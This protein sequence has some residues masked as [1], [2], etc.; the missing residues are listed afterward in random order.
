[1]KGIAR[2]NTNIVSVQSS[3]SQKNAYDIL[4]YIVYAYDII[5]EGYDKFNRMKVIVSERNFEKRGSDRGFNRRQKDY[6]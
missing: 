6:K 3:K 5:E 1:L 2:K 4:V